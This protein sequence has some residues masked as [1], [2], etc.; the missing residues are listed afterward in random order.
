MTEKEPTLLELSKRV[1][2]ILKQIRLGQ[3]TLMENQHEIFK[4]VGGKIAEIEKEP[5]EIE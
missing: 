5:L 4:Q 1:L 2:E 3:Q